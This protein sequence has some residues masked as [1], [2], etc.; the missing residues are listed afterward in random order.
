MVVEV[1][2]EVAFKVLKVFVYHLVLV[3][4]LT[5]V[6]LAFDNLVEASPVVELAYHEVV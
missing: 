1:S 4:C 2:K 5:L 6:V 3:V